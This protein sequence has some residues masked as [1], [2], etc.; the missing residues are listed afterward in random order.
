MA[1]DTRRV[2]NRGIYMIKSHITGAVAS[3][4]LVLG[5]ALTFAPSAV[6]DNGSSPAA[7]PASGDLALLQACWG[8]RVT[9]SAGHYGN[10]SWC[11]SGRYREV[12]RCETLGGYRY[13]HYGPYVWAP[14]RSTTWCNLG[15]RVVGDWLE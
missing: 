1:T 9:G 3:I 11:D 12:I 8:Q 13:V 2:D 14:E 6:A 4:V 5:G 10:S 15:D 7:V